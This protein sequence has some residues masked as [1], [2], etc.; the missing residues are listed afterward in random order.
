[1]NVRVRRVNRLAGFGSP[2]ENKDG[3]KLVAV[4]YLV[5]GNVSPT[6]IY[7]AIVF[8]YVACAI[9]SDVIHN[10]FHNITSIRKG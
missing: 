3:R 1:M 9:H 5:K 2:P 10:V 4:S 7:H 6:G 8:L